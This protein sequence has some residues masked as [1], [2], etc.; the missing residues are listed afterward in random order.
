M[1]S[2]GKCSGSCNSSNDL[3]IKICIPS[4]TKDINVKAFNMISNKNEAKTLV[5]HISCHCKRK[6]NSTTCNSNQKWNQTCVCECKN[7]CKCKKDYSRNPSTC[8]CE[9]S[10]YQKCIADDSATACD[11]I[12]YV[13]YIVSTKMANIIP[14]N[15]TSTM[16]TNELLYSTHRFIIDHITIDITITCYYC[17]HYAKY[18]SK[19]K[20]I[21]ALTK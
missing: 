1:V 10:K 4:K 15:V 18:W 5:K 6:F 20:G 14:T 12:I 11:Q 21:D 8:I 2:L 7:Y 17:H 19:Q 9:N 16:L 13:M 3:S